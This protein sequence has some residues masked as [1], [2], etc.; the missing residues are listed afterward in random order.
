MI[1]D[2][3]FQHYRKTPLNLAVYFRSGKPIFLS[4]SVDSS[5]AM[6]TNEHSVSPAVTKDFSSDFLGKF[7]FLSWLPPIIP[8][9]S[10]ICVKINPHPCRIVKGG[11]KYCMWWLYSLPEST[12]INN[13]CT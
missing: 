5:S 12:S 1:T 2:S 11:W 4:S 6:L 13:H 10:E 8:L 9:Y 3:S 7:W